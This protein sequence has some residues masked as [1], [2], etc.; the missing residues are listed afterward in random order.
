MQHA[1]TAR[2]LLARAR[3]M[4]SVLKVHLLQSATRRNDWSHCGPLLDM[5][6]LLQRVRRFRCYTFNV[7]VGKL[8]ELP[9]TISA[10]EG[11]IKHWPKEQKEKTKIL[12]KSRLNDNHNVHVSCFRQVAM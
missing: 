6:L 11:L 12:H 3:G 4:M 1:P 5:W 8:Y 7:M 9:L 10:W 2:A